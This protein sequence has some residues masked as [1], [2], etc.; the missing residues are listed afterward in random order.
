MSSPS[1]SRLNTY[2][3]IASTAA[4]G[5]AHADIVYHDVNTTIALGESAQFLVGTEVGLSAQMTFIAGSNLRG[6][7]G[8]SSWQVLDYGYGD[9]YI[10]F[11]GGFS[12][13]AGSYASL[14]RF[15][16][17]TDID[18]NNF[19]A[20]SIAWGASWNGMPGE[21]ERAFAAFKIR[22]GSVQSDPGYV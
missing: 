5:S 3:A 18:S 20:Q 7:S 17:S 2:L 4:V 11:A 14:W 15:N 12:F 8:T 10:D 9:N 22:E 19:N 21:A 1:T 6:G 16:A 13:T